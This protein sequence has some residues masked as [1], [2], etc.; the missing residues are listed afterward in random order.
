[1]SRVFIVQNQHRANPKSGALEPKFDLSPAEEY[2]DF[3]FL[4][5]PTAR[6]FNPEH[7]VGVL[8][9]RLRDFRDDDSLLLIGNPVLIGLAVAVAASFNNGRVA[10]L[11]WSGSE[12]RYVRVEA[13]L[14]TPV[15]LGDN[16][17]A[18]ADT[19]K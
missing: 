4:L 17:E 19:W 1:M 8:K 12:R 14:A 5:S 15:E 7:V 9:E 10:M 11:Q 13:D 16:T 18:W 3:E 2:G 6:P